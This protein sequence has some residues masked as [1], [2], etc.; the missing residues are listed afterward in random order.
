MATLALE[1]DQRVEEA[2]VAHP[3]GHR[4]VARHAMHDRIRLSDEEELR[5]GLYDLG[6]ELLLLCRIAATVG[7][8]LV[9]RQERLL[10]GVA[11]S[12]SVA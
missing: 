12:V 11:A 3:H 5:D 9:E 8:R 6:R 1:L 7:I 2:L 4:R 10:S